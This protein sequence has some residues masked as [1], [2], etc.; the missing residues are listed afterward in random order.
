MITSPTYPRLLRR[1]RWAKYVVAVALTGSTLL[2]RVLIGNRIEVPNLI[3]LIT[4]IILSAYWG[5]LIPGMLATSL[6]VVGAA[7]FVLPP[8]YSFYVASNTHRVQL[9]F[10]F[11]TGALISVIC[12]K[13]HREQD[14]VE[15]LLDERRQMEQAVQD[16]EMRFRTMANTISQLAWIARPDGYIIWFNDRWYEYTGT[17]A[18][19]VLGWGWQTLLDP[20]AAPDVMKEL[21]RAVKSGTPFEMEFKLRGTDETFRTFLIR[22]EPIKDAGGRVTQWFGTNTDVET[23][24][25]VE[26]EVQQLNTE[27]EQRVL[28][29]TAQLEAANK[30]LE[31][32]SYSVSHDLRAPL[33][34]VDGYSMAL[35]DEFG[36]QLPGE[37]QRLLRVI[38]DG[39]QQ[40]GH[41]IDDLL[42]FARLSRLPLSKQTVEMQPMV[43]DIVRTLQNENSNRQ[44]DVNISTLPSCYGDA[45]VLRQ[46]WTNLLSNAFKYTRKRDHAIIDVGAT[47]QTGETI[48]FVRDNGTGFDM[49]YAD[50]LFGVFQRLH[51][52]EDYEGTGVGLAIVQRIVNRHGGRVWADSVEGS[53]STFYFTLQAEN[54]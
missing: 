40:M 43:R 6:S 5:G 42:T 47:Q 30:E 38:R 14:R 39:A 10:M 8:V 23:L 34:A 46:V 35:L 26:A 7:V 21:T 13:F 51:R 27:L 29:R 44:I 50:K 12:E 33:R 25:R 1:S 37:A 45:S 49:R 22:G 53:G 28:R 36:P 32:F 19:Q 24:K 16:S 17:M 15:A 41:L 3:L 31:A 54:N 4:P 20:S 11:I 2:V 18:E 52:A 48:Y 9:V